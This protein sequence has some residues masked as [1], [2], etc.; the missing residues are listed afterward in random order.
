M[1]FSFFNEIEKQKTRKSFLIQGSPGAGKTTLAEKCG[2]LAE[3]Q[4]WQVVVMNIPTLLNL[5]E[6]RKAVG[7]EPRW[8][9]GE[10]V[11]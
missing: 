3:K 4:G 9:F 1:I 7:R 2:A 6:F 10:N 5:K 8:N 11:K